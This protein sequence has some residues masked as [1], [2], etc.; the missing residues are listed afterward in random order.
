MFYASFGLVLIDSDGQCCGNTSKS[1]NGIS[2]T[3]SSIRH[4]FQ[5]SYL[6][7]DVIWSRTRP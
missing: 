1:E 3:K 2:Q 4:Y 5:E 7:K 6:W